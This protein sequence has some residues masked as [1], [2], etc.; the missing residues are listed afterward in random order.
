M[1]TKQLQSATKRPCMEASCHT[2]KQ[3]LAVGHTCKGVAPYPYI[4]QHGIDS[5]TIL[6]ETI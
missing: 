1:S 5:Q 2:A 4:W 6:R 3:Y